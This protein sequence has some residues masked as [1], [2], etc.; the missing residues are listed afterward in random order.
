MAA[1]EQVLLPP[2]GLRDCHLLTEKDGTQL[3]GCTFAGLPTRGHHLH[4]L[5]LLT[6][7]LLPTP[8]HDDRGTVQ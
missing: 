1:T 8:E 5:K 3:C 2:Q 6:Y 7:Q 4:H